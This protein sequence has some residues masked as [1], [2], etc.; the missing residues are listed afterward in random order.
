MQQVTLV[1]KIL[2]IISTILFPVAVMVTLAIFF[3]GHSTGFA[4]YPVMIVRD[5]A[6]DDVDDDEDKSDDLLHSVQ[7]LVCVQ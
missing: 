2:K 1:K 3:T 6:D 4:L 7:S 5:D